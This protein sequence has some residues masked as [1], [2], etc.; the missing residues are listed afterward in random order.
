MADLWEWAKEKF[1]ELAEYGA[2]NPTEFFQYLFLII[3]PILLI[4]LVMSVYLLKEM[5]KKE[6]RLKSTGTKR[7]LKS[8]NRVGRGHKKSDWTEDGEL[9]NNWNNYGVAWSCS[10]SGV[11]YVLFPTLLPVE[12]AAAV[13]KKSHWNMCA[14]TRAGTCTSDWDVE[15]NDYNQWLCTAMLC[16]HPSCQGHTPGTE[17]WGTCYRVLLACGW[18]LNPC[19]EF[20]AKN[21]LRPYSFLFCMCSIMHVHVEH[22]VGV[23][24]SGFVVSLDPYSF[25][26]II[27]S[28]PW[29]GG[30]LSFCNT[31]FRNIEFF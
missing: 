23:T 18:P 14:L 30:Q 26:H 6:K 21:I 7:S 13:C 10:L 25:C 22:R 17:C 16:R 11:C 20:C 12:A 2:Q 29:S 8:I 28:C 4:C 9:S 5:E 1:V 31:Q 27:E 3:S 15:I 19:N 24:F